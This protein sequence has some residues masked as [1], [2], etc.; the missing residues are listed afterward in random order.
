VFADRPDGSTRIRT[1]DE[2]SIDAFQAADG[3]RLSHRTIGATFGG[4][5]LA[6]SST[7]VVAISRE[8]YLY[9]WTSKQPPVFCSRAT[10]H[11]AV[12]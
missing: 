10:L 6:A 7:L 11:A 8:G 5:P 4:A 3:R 9:G 12:P 2:I 1:Q